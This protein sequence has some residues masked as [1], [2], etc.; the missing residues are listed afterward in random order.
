MA[1]R[2]GL[3][4]LFYQLINYWGLPLRGESKLVGF[5][6]QASL[7]I[8]AEPPKAKD[9]SQEKGSAVGSQ[10]P[11]LPEAGS[12]GRPPCRVIEPL[13]RPGSGSHSSDWSC[14]V[15]AAH[16][17]TLPRL[18]TEHGSKHFRTHMHGLV[19]SPH[20]YGNRGPREL[21]S[22]LTLISYH[23]LLISSQLEFGGQ[24]LHMAHN[25][26][27]TTWLD[28]SNLFYCLVGSELFSSYNF[29]HIP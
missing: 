26:F 4:Y 9:K 23:H 18:Q 3:L 19:P 8:P 2:D 28:S 24:T 7:P 11:L 13:L 22:H 5:S 12:E 1:L 29:I 21:T 17:V 15:Y 20:C 6:K 25:K 27:F 10:Q 16:T 14:W